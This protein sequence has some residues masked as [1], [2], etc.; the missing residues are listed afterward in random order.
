MTA[1]RIALGLLATSFVVG[2]K[3]SDPV[4]PAVAVGP[5]PA[6]GGWSPPPCNEQAG[7][8]WSLS[9]RCGHFVDREGRVVILRGVNAR[10]RGLFDAD[11][12]EG[13]TPLM[14]PIPELP[15]EDLARMRKIGFDL[16]RLPIN[17]SAIEPEDED[18]PTYDGAYLDRIVALV[19]AAKAADVRVLLDFHQ[20]AYSKWIG[21]DGAPLWA[22]VPPPEKILEGPL[23]DLSARIL[24]PQVQR[25]YDTFFSREKTDGARLRARFAQM[26]AAVAA[27]VKGD[28]TVIGIEAY[29]EPI[30]TDDAL[31]A[32]HEEVAAAI[33]AADPKRLFV[34][35]PPAV[36]NF[37]DRALIPSSGLS[38]G[39]TVYAPHVYTKV[40]AQGCDD[41]CRAD[42]EIGDLRPSNESAREE[43]EAWRAPLLIG[44]WGFFPTNPRFSD[45]VAAQLDLQD[46]YQASSALWVWKE[47]SEGSWGFF[48]HDAAAD[49]WTERP[50]VRKA[51]ARV[52]P[53][54]I[55]GWPRRFWWDGK[56]RRFVLE[57]AG[58]A[59]VTA[60]T[61][62]HV[63]LA[64]D[65]AA[66]WRV[67]C[68]GREL[69][70][71]PDDR[72]DLSIACS[73]AGDHRVVVEAR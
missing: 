6:L 66:S 29:N 36:R 28:E 71:K 41:A 61:V 23:D 51:F 24:S 47:N 38:I 72:G 69:D 37:S 46:A 50:A 10:V 49:R 7:D 1:S 67:T 11:L 48:D 52:M 62:V 64:E 19:A 43:S 34:F 22:I 68:D 26:A 63:P 31:R 70:A 2:C 40:F 60:P 14:L 18:P 4:E 33:R 9:T 21:Q 17:W 42:F 65:S 53:R 44:E 16:L 73:G 32:F 39:G 45:Y 12:G 30:A 54:A 35:E 25:A 59:A 5:D 8:W 55:A 15:P 3:A 57:Y 58:D 56:A 27:K 20:D 13:R